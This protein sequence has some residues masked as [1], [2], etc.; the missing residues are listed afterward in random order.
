[1]S[2]ALKNSAVSGKV[3]Q[4][5]V[6]S[7]QSML[8]LEHHQQR[9]SSLRER[10]RQFEESSHQLATYMTATSETSRSLQ[11][12]LASAAELPK[13][14]TQ[15]VKPESYTTATQSNLPA[16]STLVVARHSEPI[17]EKRSPTPNAPTPSTTVFVHI[18]Q[19]RSL[20]AEYRS[21]G[22][23][24]SL[25]IL[26]YFCH[27]DA[28]GRHS[29]CFLKLYDIFRLQEEQQVMVV[30]EWF[31]LENTLQHRMWGQA[32]TSGSSSLVS[33]TGF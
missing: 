7:G 4:F 17:N 28:Q 32:W 12:T 19:L 2:D 21:R 23:A 31:Y 20:P 8:D 18:L 22:L 9:V 5:S 16:T 29:A 26:K 3:G 14:R 30:E 10:Q 27:A 1:M 24:E 13:H 15:L 6:V 25:K 11:V 33:V